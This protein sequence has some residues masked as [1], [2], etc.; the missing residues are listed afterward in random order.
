VYSNSYR[1]VSDGLSTQQRREE[2]LYDYAARPWGA[3]KVVPY[4]LRR[5]YELSD[6]PYSAPLA[7]EVQQLG[8]SDWCVNDGPSAP[9]LLIETE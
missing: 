8:L 1:E 6:R 2:L 4:M 9:E 7:R 5:R 3:C